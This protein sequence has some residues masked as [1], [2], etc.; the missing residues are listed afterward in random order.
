MGTYECGGSVKVGRVE[1]SRRLRLG[2]GAYAY[3]CCDDEHVPPRDFSTPAP[4]ERLPPSDSR[5]RFRPRS[6]GIGEDSNIE[7]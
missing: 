7:G 6:N 3:D 4:I 2:L 1:S 5:Q